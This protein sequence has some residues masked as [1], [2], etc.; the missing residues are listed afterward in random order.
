L[1][2]RKNSDPVGKAPRKGNRTREGKQCKPPTAKVADVIDD[3]NNSPFAILDGIIQSTTS[4]LTHKTGTRSASLFSP[5]KRLEPLLRKQCAWLL[6]PGK[7]G[8]NFTVLCTSVQTLHDAA[9][10]CRSLLEVVFDHDDKVRSFPLKSLLSLLDSARMWPEEHFLKIAKFVTA[11]PYAHFLNA[12]SSKKQDGSPTAFNDLPKVPEGYKVKGSKPR[13]QDILS[14]ALAKYLNNRLAIGNHRNNHLW[15][16]WLQGIKRGCAAATDFTV[17]GSLKGHSI[18][19]SKDGCISKMEEVDSLLLLSSVSEKAEIIWDRGANNLVPPALRKK[20]KSPEIITST[21]EGQPRCVPT[22]GASYES[23]FSDGG[24]HNWLYEYLHYGVDRDDESRAVPIHFEEHRD[25]VCMWYS[26]RTGVREER[27]RYLNWST[28]ELVQESRRPGGRFDHTNVKIIPLKEPLKIRTISKG[29]AL[30]YWLAKPC[31]KTMR[32]TLS[33]FD[34]FALTGGSLEVSHLDWLWSKTNDLIKRV[35]RFCPGIDLDFSHWVSGD[36][37]GATDGVDIKATKASFEA[38]LRLAK[39]DLDHEHKCQ[40]FSTLQDVLYEQTL[41][42]QKDGPEVTKQTNG[43][44]MGSNLSFPI[45]CVVNLIGYWMTVEEYTGLRIEPQDLPVLVNGDDILFR[46]PKPRPEDPASFYELWKS[47]ITKLGFELSVGKNYVH[48]KVFTVNSECWHFKQ[49]QAGRPVFRRTRHLDVGILTKNDP[50]QRLEN[51]IMPLAD[52]L[53][54]VLQGAWN[55]QRCWKRLKHYYAKDIK[56]W[57]AYGKSDRPTTFNVFAHDLL[58]G[59]GVDFEFEDHKDGKDNLDP[60]FTSFQR[61]FATFCRKSLTEVSDFTEFKKFERLAL[62][63]S[64][65][66]KGLTYEVPRASVPCEWKEVGD[67]VLEV[68]PDIRSLPTLSREQPKTSESSVRTFTLRRLTDFRKVYKDAGFKLDKLP[69]HWSKV[70]S[71]KRSDD[72]STTASEGSSSN[73]TTVSSPKSRSEPRDA[74][75]LD[76][77]Q[78]GRESGGTFLDCVCKCCQAR[79]PHLSREDL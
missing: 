48:D 31:Q 47:N 8:T 27:G 14:G 13:L 65:K 57:T 41:H 36:Y 75:I 32:R 18:D 69:G 39:V 6:T 46:T 38:F 59:L 30:K 25:L 51:R 63:A 44:L 62:T 28:A 19:L 7:D 20:T 55:K 78:T 10:L 64:T 23:K 70:L 16:S 24:T 49:G 50:N 17:L 37:K 11:W 61:R 29:N 15:W 72:V 4:K 73:G 67:D 35:R 68:E 66:G 52:R 22:S 26:P 45:L 77:Q 2:D 3:N 1:A 79:C 33:A 74:C 21:K 60:G 43:Q 54:Q 34:Q 56:A 42:Y 5:G 76:G 9:Y 53:N 12:W 71:R 58:G 40:Y